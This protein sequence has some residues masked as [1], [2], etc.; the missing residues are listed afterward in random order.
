[1]YLSLF[2]ISICLMGCQST[3]KKTY[4]STYSEVKSSE[5]T[6][7]KSLEEIYTKDLSVYVLY[8]P[9]CPV[10]IKNESTILSEFKSIDKSLKDFYYVDATDGIPQELHNVLTVNALEGAKTPYIVVI[11]NAVRSFENNQLFE[12][13]IS[14][15]LDKKETIKA[16][17][18]ALKLIIKGKN[19]D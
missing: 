1:M 3:I 7:I 5:K 16:T 12:P 13:V 14:V 18:H 8:K 9:K 2:T 17:A 11:D 19:N 6:V 4:P 15:R 10:C